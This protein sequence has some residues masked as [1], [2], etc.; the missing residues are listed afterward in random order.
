MNLDAL[1]IRVPTRVYRLG[2]T[3]YLPHYCDAHR[4]VAADGS[5]LSTAQLVKLQAFKS[6]EFLWPRRWLIDRQI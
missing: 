4:W 1:H 2:G 3:L 6:M 5:V